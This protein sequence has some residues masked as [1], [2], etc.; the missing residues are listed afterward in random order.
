MKSK[1]AKGL[2]IYVAVMLV[3][4]F[5]GLFVFWQFISAYELSRTAGVMDRYMETELRPELEQAVAEFVEGR[6]EYESEDAQTQA[7]MDIL[8]SGALDYRKDPE[9]FHERTPVYIIR[10]D[11]QE[12]GKVWLKPEDGG[13]LSFG[14]PRWEVRSS[15]FDL[16]FQLGFDFSRF[17]KN[18]VIYAPPDA[19]VT[20]NGVA[21]S[22]GEPL[23]AVTPELQPFYGDLAQ[24]P[25]YLVSQLGLLTEPEV[26][27]AGTFDVKQGDGYAVIMPRC[28][29]ETEAELTKLCEDF[30]RAYIAYTSNAVDGP[31]IVQQYLVP[32]GSMYERMTASMDGMSWVHGVTSTMSDLQIVGFEYYG[33][34]AI[35]EANYVL[36]SN[37]TA[38]DNDMKIIL[39]ETENGWRVANIELQ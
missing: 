36:T 28:D 4:I 33:S 15:G 17:V 14:L 24:K 10:L 8:N 19:E 16:G 32:G 5:A 22:D 25:E 31:G 26:D 2:L 11:K 13:L 34:A 27:A 37:G 35:A 38:T 21:L 3:I 1:F 30:V 12:L 39:T 20:V 23:N 7:L 9:R 29:E 6:T 18:Y